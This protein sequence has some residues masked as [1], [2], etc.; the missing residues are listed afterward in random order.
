MN[1]PL[2]G[3]ILTIKDLAQDEEDERRLQR[4]AVME[5]LLDRQFSLAGFRFGWDSVA[6]LIPIFGDT[7]TTALSAWIIWEAHKAGAPNHLKARMIAHAGVDYLIGLV[8]LVGDVGDAFYKANT[9]N[10]RLLKRHLEDKR[11]SRARP[12]RRKS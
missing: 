1:K 11:A 2:E 4:I 7:L 6:G 9:R 3:E 10:V 8:P 5:K 12:A